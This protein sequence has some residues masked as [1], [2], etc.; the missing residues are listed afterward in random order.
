MLARTLCSPSDSVLAG[1]LLASEGVHSLKAC[2]GE[3]GQVGTL[4][5]G[6]KITDLAK[7]LR[8]VEKADTECDLA[9]DTQPFSSKN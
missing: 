3:S 6:N 8:L 7:L 5:F 9:Q 1:N 4:P 2:Q